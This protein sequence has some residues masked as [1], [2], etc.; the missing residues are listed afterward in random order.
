MAEKVA[1]QEIERLR[2]ELERIRSQGPKTVVVTQRR[3]PS[4]TDIKPISRQPVL[5]ILNKIKESTEKIKNGN[6][7]VNYNEL[8][9]QTVEDLRL[10]KLDLKMAERE[11]F[12]RQLTQHDWGVMSDY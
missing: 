8:N 12:G 2:R 10:H 5:D 9:L 6:G 1:Q 4:P 3:S 11:I 7:T